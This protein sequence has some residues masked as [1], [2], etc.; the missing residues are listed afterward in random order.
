MVDLSTL[1]IGDTVVFTDGLTDVVESVKISK[2]GKYDICFKKNGSGKYTQGG[3]FYTTVGTTADYNIA[4]IIPKSK[5]ES[6]KPKVDLH[7][8]AEGYSVYCDDGLVH[9]VDNVTFDQN[10]AVITFYDFGTF[11]FNYDGT[12][13]QED[14][15]VGN[16]VHVLHGAPEPKEPTKTVD[17][18]DPVNRP[19]HY[20]SGG[21]ECIEAIKASMVKGAY[22]GYLKGNI[23]KYIWRYEKK[24]NPVEDLKKA[25]TYLDWLI[26]ENEQ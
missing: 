16:I 3:I 5:E 2:D 26:K 10:Y 4:E 25:R 15:E 8:I 22:K 1:K 21:I 17:Q 20:T 12:K 23:L 9:V 11:E 13:F 24:E 19:I 6:D 14:A 7:D 18:A